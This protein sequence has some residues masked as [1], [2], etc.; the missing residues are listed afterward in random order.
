VQFKFKSE[1]GTFQMNI[2]EPEVDNAVKIEIENFGIKI[3]TS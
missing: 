1:D 2:I 3:I